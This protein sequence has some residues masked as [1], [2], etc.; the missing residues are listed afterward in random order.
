M[1]RE[2]ADRSFAFEKVNRGGGAEGA[3]WGGELQSNEEEYRGGEARLIMEK[4]EST[5]QF[6]H[7]PIHL[8]NGSSQGETEV[9]YSLHCRAPGGV[10]IYVYR[11]LL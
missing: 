10:G 4:R 3:G 1:S 8:P 6:P 9:R 2:S 5:L 7:S 11:L